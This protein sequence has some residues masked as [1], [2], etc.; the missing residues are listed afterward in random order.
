MEIVDPVN[1]KPPTSILLQRSWIQTPY[2]KYQS[3]QKDTDPDPHTTN[4]IIRIATI[5]TTTTTNIVTEK[6]LHAYGGT[7]PMQI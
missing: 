4:S 2:P 5:T 3:W 1:I 7:L 6:K